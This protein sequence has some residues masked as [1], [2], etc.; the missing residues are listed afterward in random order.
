MICFMCTR[1][2]WSM[3]SEAVVYNKLPPHL[4]IQQPR[5]SSFQLGIRLALPLAFPQVGFHSPGIRNRTLPEEIQ[6]K[7]CQPFWLWHKGRAAMFDYAIRQAH[8]W[9]GDLVTQIVCVFWPHIMLGRLQTFSRRLIV[10]YSALW[11]TGFRTLRN[12]SLEYLH[13]WSKFHSV[14]IEPALVPPLPP[15]HHPW[16]THNN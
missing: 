16:V 12:Q 7:L 15:L 2:L 3:A 1:W 6:A 11:M 9:W 4:Q 10:G 5:R 13:F 14:C 8:P